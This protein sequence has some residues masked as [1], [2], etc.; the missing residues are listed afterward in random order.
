MNRSE[1]EQYITDM[2]EYALVHGREVGTWYK[3]HNHVYGVAKIAEK[4]S[5]YLDE[6]DSEKAYVLGLLHDAGKI[7]EQIERR[8]HGIIGYE[9]LKDKD[10]AAARICLT[11]SFHENIFRANL[12]IDKM[13]F[14]RDDDYVFVC[15]YLEEH[16]ADK[17]DILIQLCDD[18]AN[19][20][21]FVTL[22]QRA[23][24]FA[25]RH[26]LPVPAVL[27]EKAEKLKAYFDDRLGCDIYTLY[28][29]LSTDFM[30]CPGNDRK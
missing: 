8:F 9:A 19:C 5:S 23:D 29:E 11:H 3:F 14:G 1:A 22:Q 21:G 13:F 2:L 16:Q 7:R 12:G 6:Y 27:Y 10:P 25:L 20:S 28:D 4:I 18:L 17:Y 26:H 30:L 24:E 15:R